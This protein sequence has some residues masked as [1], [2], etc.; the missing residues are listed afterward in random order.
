METIIYLAC[1]NKNIYVLPLQANS[2]ESCPKKDR[3]V[4]SGHRNP[5]TCMSLTVDEQYLI[6][7]TTCGLLYVWNTLDMSLHHTFEIHKDKGSVSN[8][9]PIHRP[10]SLYGLNVN[11]KG[12]KNVACVLDKELGKFIGER[13]EE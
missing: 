1:Q 9:L 3:K 8:I 2:L 10:L 13:S 4:L 11:M 7:G 12:G 6:S 5:I